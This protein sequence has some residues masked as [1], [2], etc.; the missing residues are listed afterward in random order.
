MKSLVFA[1]GYTL[2]YIS[3]FN[4]KKVI[5]NPFGAIKQVL[6]RFIDGFL[7]YSFETGTYTR[8]Q[9]GNYEYYPLFKIKKIKRF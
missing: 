7:K 6:I 8:C 5:K 2:I 9:V 3:S 4:Q 1:S